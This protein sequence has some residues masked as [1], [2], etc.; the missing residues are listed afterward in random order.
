MNGILYQREDNS[1][2][3][4]IFL[5]LE[6]GISLNI[7]FIILFLLGQEISYIIF[8]ILIIDPLRRFIKVYGRK[9]DK[10]NFKRSN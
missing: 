6:I 8:I 5:I 10:K 4:I 7:S 2:G 3:P 1:I 9:V